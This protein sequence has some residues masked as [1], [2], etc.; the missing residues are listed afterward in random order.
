MKV[1]LYT[2]TQD[3]RVRCCWIVAFDDGRRN[4]FQSSADLPKEALETIKYGSHKTVFAEGC[5]QDIYRR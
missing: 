2:Y 4:H 3:G 1:T 5:K